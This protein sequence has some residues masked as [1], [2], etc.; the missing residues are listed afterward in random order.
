MSE[1]ERIRNVVPSLNS[2]QLEAISTIEGPVLV[3]AG[4]GT[5]KTLTLALRTMYIILTGKAEPKNILVTT[6]TEKA[7]FEL[8]DR[9]SQIARRLGYK[10]QL[11]ELNV[12]TVH[13]ICNKF[14]ERFLPYTP[15]KKNYIVLE[16]LTQTLFLYENFEKIFPKPSNANE[17][18]LGRWHTKW[19]AIKGI[20]PYFNK[21]TEELIDV[22]QLEQS[23]EQFLVSLS[24][25]YSRYRSTMLESNKVDFAHLQTIFLSLIHDPEVG[26]QVKKNVKY[27]MVDEYQDTN[28][29][30]EQIFM[31]LAKPDNNLCVVG[32]DDQALYRFRG[33]TVRN[34][35]EFHKHF[36]RCLQVNLTLNYRSHKDVIK[37]YNS[38]MDSLEWDG[39][40][41]RKQIRPDPEG[42]F[43][44]Y[45]AVFSIWGSNAKDE[46]KR[47][48]E[49]VGF[50]KENRIIQ[51][52]SDIALLLTSVRLSNSAHYLRA[53]NQANI[54]YFAPRARAY[55]E[56]EEVQL[57]VAC[58]AIIFG[59]YGDVLDSFPE[60]AYVENAIVNLKSY[61]G[62]ALS[63]YL[64]RKVRQIEDLTQGSLNL[65]ILDYLYQLMAYRP[66]S[67]YLKDETA[68]RNIAIFSG[69][70]SI[71]QDYYRISL[72]TAKNKNFVR[73]YLFGSFLHFLIQGGMDDYEDPD[74]PIPKG[75]VQIM[76]I[77]QSKGLEFPVV[78]VGSLDRVF[79][80]QKQVDRD[81]GRFSSRGTYET[82]EQMTDF[83]RMR[84][85]Y[86]A[87][88]RPQKM[89]VLTTHE[90]PQHWFSPIWEGLDQWPYVKKKA[91]QAQSFFSKPQ[92]VPKKSYSLSS[93]NVYEI[94]P[95][96]YLFYREYSFQPSRSAQMLFGTLVHQTI[97]D[98]HNYI[99]KEKEQKI[100]YLTIEQWFEDNYRTLITSG[101]RP[102]RKE[103]KE[104]A[105]K[106]V[107]N[108]YRQNNDIF[109]RLQE[110][111][112]DVS[113]EKDDY[114][115]TG[116]IDL[117]MGRNE[118]FEILDFKT[119]SKPAANDPV[120]NR[121]FHQLCLY[122]YILKERYQ[123][124][125][126]K[127]YI[128]WTSEED[129]KNALMEFKYS[130]D[131]IAKTGGH[132]ENIITRIRQKEFRVQNP[133][134]PKKVC[135]ECDFRFYCS[136]QGIV[137]SRKPNNTRI[138]THYVRRDL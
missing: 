73:Y 128:Y 13:S 49:L 102:I 78:A 7:A 48:S 45:P 8:R 51:D 67:E 59:F 29:V 24:E 136:S 18:F 87:F 123:K 96:Q 137:K 91:L 129:K 27:I 97:E 37:D 133:P 120:I 30:Q 36:D 39:F 100:D 121:Y 88:S 95:Q 125:A 6:F 108:Y 38:F 44:S 76:T 47:F 112:V 130:E 101:L 19:S 119:H 124:D 33:A 2:D 21:I 85:F 61:V 56:N 126:E 42:V 93:V 115:L 4:P 53:L 14:I 10:G 66:F 117:L 69:L 11:H 40:R 23:G 104:A 82:E 63:D 17:P 114:I 12:G 1:I 138:R 77:H 116:K 60:K 92:F 9:I 22:E 28:F 25:Y 111:E 83:D 54:P 71:F 5:G 89:L 131:P 46:A 122:A 134:D 107:I 74:N 35:L 64:Q 34:I 50:L 94:C 118:R 31:A 80:V 132:F 75:F 103:Q 72:V 57:L 110:T 109:E 113:V 26:E 41:F 68:S 105:L 65:V 135:G 70:L 98:V 43:P 52:Y 86:V 90:T 3:I 20:L 32:D 84:H 15:L 79:R 106:H 58:F 81:L 127:L 99:L 16:E 55:F 62:T